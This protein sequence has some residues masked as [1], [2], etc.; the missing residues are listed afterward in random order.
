MTNY[1]M[2][3]LDSQR[4]FLLFKVKKKSASEYRTWESMFDQ[5]PLRQ[6]LTRE[7]CFVAQSPLLQYSHVKLM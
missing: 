5:T 7:S 1:S 2:R 6:R 4:L 3:F